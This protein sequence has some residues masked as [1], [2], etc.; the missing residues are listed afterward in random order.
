M[1]YNT[2]AVG[3]DG[4]DTS[5]RAVRTAASLAA[6]YDA[7][8]IVVSAFGSHDKVGTRQ[9]RDAEIPVISEDMSQ[10][11][12]KA[13]Q[14]IATEEGA[15]RIHVIAKSGDPVA[16]MLEVGKYYQ[17]D[18]LVVGNKGRNSVRDRV[19]GSV[20]TELMRK[21]YVDVVVAN[22]SDDR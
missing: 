6:V 9:E 2:I 21:A 22:T 14:D 3:T 20:A 10:T 11:F 8:L 19:L 17:V 13:A 7:D 5:L 4:S 15:K 16:T 18:C 1:K 12:L